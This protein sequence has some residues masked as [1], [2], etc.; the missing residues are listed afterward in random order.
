MDVLGKRLDVLAFWGFVWFAT[1]GDLVDAWKLESDAGA[2][3]SFD[4]EGGLSLL[5]SL[6]GARPGGFSS[7]GRL[8]V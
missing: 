8:D 4:R 5:I 1:N 7:V 2:P 6:F 3:K